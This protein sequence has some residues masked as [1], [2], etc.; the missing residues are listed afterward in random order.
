MQF[1][2]EPDLLIYETRPVS[3]LLILS[4]CFC[5]RSNEPLAKFPHVSGSRS[6]LFLQVRRAFRS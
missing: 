3:S 5:R 6:K 4:G 1:L 2:I